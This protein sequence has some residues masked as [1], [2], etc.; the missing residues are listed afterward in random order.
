MSINEKFYF[1]N[2]FF[3]F[4]LRF[5]FD[6]NF[7]IFIFDFENYFITIFFHVIVYLISKNSFI[8]CSSS[9]R[10]VIFENGNNKCQIA[11][12]TKIPRGTLKKWLTPN[13][14]NRQN[15]RNTYIP[16]TNFDDFLNTPEKRQAYSYILAIYLCDGCIST[17]KTF[18]APSIRFF[19]DSKYP[20]NTKN[21]ADKL[22]LLFPNNSVITFKK[23]K[24]NCLVVLAYSKLLLDL[25]PQHGK[26]VKH[27]REIKLTEWQK[28]IIAE[29]PQDFIKGCIE[30]D[31]CIYEQKVG[32]YSYKRYSFTNK[33]ED[34][35]NIF[36]WVLSLI[37]INKEKY[38]NPK[39]I[40]VIQNFKPDSIKILQKIINQ[41]E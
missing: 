20:I 40:Y 22:K 32:N 14:N 1:V 5:Y 35:I 6:G 41:K 17:Y 30:S 39:E 25:F 36:L 21:W 8:F 27:L 28:Q 3:N 33:S 29:Y 11:R 16:I 9:F 24:A 13:Y 31:G 37:G 26:G 12:I 18:R 19:N 10:Q 4:F 38:W 7:I 15:K 2:L 34:I 23:P